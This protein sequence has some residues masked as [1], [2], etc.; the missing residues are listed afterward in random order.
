[1]ADISYLPVDRARD[2]DIARSVHHRVY[3]DV[4]VR[5]FGDWNESLQDRFFEAKWSETPHQMIVLDGALIG[6]LSVI[7]KPEC[8]YLNELQIL[9]E[10]QGK[11]FGGQIIKDLQE[12]GRALH[13]PVRLQVLLQNHAQALYSRHGFVETTRTETHVCMEWRASDC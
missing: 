9:P 1:V 7:N 5:Q 4:V 10:Y 8:V 12:K 6:F 13:L 2:F 11:G 3:R